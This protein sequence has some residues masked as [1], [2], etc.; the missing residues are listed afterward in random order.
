LL[1]SSKQVCERIDF[2]SKQSTDEAKDAE[3]H[4]GINTEENFDI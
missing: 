3:K 1:E 4:K 2:I